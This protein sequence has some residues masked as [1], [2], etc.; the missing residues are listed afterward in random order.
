MRLRDSSN[1]KRTLSPKTVGRQ[2]AA[3]LFGGL[4]GRL[5]FADD[6]EFA[7]FVFVNNPLF[8]GWHE[9]YRSNSAAKI[10]NA[11]FCIESTTREIAILVQAKTSQLGQPRLIGVH[12]TTSFGLSSMGRGFYSTSCFSFVNILKSF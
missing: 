12:E 5:R 4:S 3:Q 2:F 1:P 9:P 8:L 7:L 10:E 11:A 6:N